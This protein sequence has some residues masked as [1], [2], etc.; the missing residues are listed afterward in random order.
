MIGALVLLTNGDGP[1][2][3]GFRFRVLVQRL[4]DDLFELHG[5]KLRATVRGRGG[6]PRRLVKAVTLH[7]AALE[8]DEEE[9]WRARV[10]LDV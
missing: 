1:F 7:G 8:R 2:Q 10:V 9:G 3:H 5:T 6:E 4:A